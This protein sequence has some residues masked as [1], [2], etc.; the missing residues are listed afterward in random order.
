[1]M[2]SLLGPQK[3]HH[4]MQPAEDRYGDSAENTVT[5]QERCAAV[6]INTFNHILLDS[7]YSKHRANL[8]AFILEKDVPGAEVDI[9]NYELVALG[10]G[11][12]WYQGWQEYQGLLVHD[13]HALV[14]ARR[15]LLRYLYKEIKMYYS[16]LPGA[17]DRCIFCPSQES[18]AL[19]LKPGIFLHLYL[20]NIPPG[21][22][23]SHLSWMERTTAPLSIHAKGSLRLLS[24]CPPSVLAARVCSMSAT[25]KLLRWNVLGVQGALL[26]HIMEP[27]Y[28]TSLVIGATGHQREDL[29]QIVLERLKAPLDL[30]LFPAYTMHRPFLFLGPEIN[31]KQPPA[32]HP[33]HSFNWSKGDESV[34]VVDGSIGRPV[35]SAQASSNFPGSRIC[36]GAM[37]MYY[38][39]V[40]Q[41]L[42]KEQLPDSY[43]HTKASADQYQRVKNHFYL[44]LNAHGLGMWPRKLCVDRFRAITW[45]RPDGES[46]ARFQSDLH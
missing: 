42:G 19:V 22:A 33:N 39:G 10:T 40:Q 30:S 7:D 31:S 17:R 14:V 29:S 28:I 26:S 41:L 3:Q 13:S 6:T 36:K 34:E 11:Y 24:N 5:H 44:H 8:A 1:M 25:D 16:N 37:L 4:S 27:L 15:A 20:N 45:Q 35:D 12:T 46:C 18:Q 38:I 43:Y 2:E 32:I 23:Q 9:D 21:A